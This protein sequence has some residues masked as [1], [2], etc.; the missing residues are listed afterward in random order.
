MASPGTDD[1]L[2]RCETTPGLPGRLAQHASRVCLP[3]SAQPPGGGFE[4]AVFEEPSQQLI[5]SLLRGQLP[6]DL[7]VGAGQQQARLDL[8][9][10]AHQEKEL[11]HVVPVA[12]DPG[13]LHILQICGDDLEKRHLEEVYLLFQD[14][15]Q[16]Q[17]E[18]TLV[19][20]ELEFDGSQRGLT[21]QEASQEGDV[22]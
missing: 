6:L 14:Q 9:Q 7:G 19:D 17:V 21:V 20:V 16:Q 8:H 22:V 11:G 10:K 13:R 4:L 18:R 12:D 5:S 1:V 15:R 2:H 3:K